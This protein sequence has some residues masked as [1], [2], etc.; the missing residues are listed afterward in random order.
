MV[1]DFRSFH[2]IDEKENPSEGAVDQILN[3]FFQAYGSIVSKIDNYPDLAKD[4]TEVAKEK[5]S[6]KIG[7]AM[8]NAITKVADKVKPEYKEAADQ[9]IVA[10]KKIKEA[11]ESVIKTDEGKK[12]L[13]KIK[14]NIYERIIGYLDSLKKVTQEAPEKP[15]AQSETEGVSE[16]NWYNQ[17]LDLN[18]ILEKNT[19]TEERSEILTDIAPQLSLAKDLA[20]NPATQNLGTTYKKLASDLEKLQTELS[21]ENEASWKKMKRRERKER[22][23]QIRDE[24]KGIKDQLVSVSLEGIKSLG[25][26]RNVFS[27]IKEASDLITGSLKLIDAVDKAT[28]EE[29]ERKAKDAETE[30]EKPE[31]EETFTEIQSGTIKSQNL[32]KKGPNFEEIKK[33]QELINSFLPDKEKIKADGLYGKNTENAIKKIAS[34]YSG[35]APDL[36]KDVDGKSMTPEFQK[37]LSRMEKNKDKVQELFK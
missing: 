30:E 27:K 19:F 12:E 18:F 26:D 36:L 28:K 4:L 21:S 9:M 34:I 13:E 32:Q 17:D 7:Q 25:I 31:E 1:L 33:N 14:D 15:E 37:F 16:K 24:I 20:K 3:L 23:D 11:F 35:L 10:G 29:D 2:R 5:V 22:L 6:D 8:L